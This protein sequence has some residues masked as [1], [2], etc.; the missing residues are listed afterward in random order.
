MVVALS[1]R[2]THTNIPIPSHSDT[3]LLQKSLTSAITTPSTLATLLSSGTPQGRRAILYL[4]VPRTR[5][6]FTPAMIEELRECDRARDGLSGKAQ[7][8][9]D[10][11]VNGETPAAGATGGTSKKSAETRMEEVRKGASESL[12]Q[13]VTDKGAEMVRDPGGSLVVAEIMLSADGGKC[14]FFFYLSDSQTTSR[15]LKCLLNVFD[16]ALNANSQIN[17]P[18][19]QLSSKPLLN[20]IH[21]HHHHPPLRYLPLPLLPSKSTLLRLN[22]LLLMTPTLSTSHILLGCT[23]LS[24]KVDTSTIPPKQSNQVLRGMRGCLRFG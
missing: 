9:L 15:F 12:I 22:H 3:K 14:L 20:L 16:V 11:E 6:H 8:G 5:R 23:K 13:W 21:R 24:F 10:A 17:L 2:D 18:Q 4:I 1:C 19:P 7:T